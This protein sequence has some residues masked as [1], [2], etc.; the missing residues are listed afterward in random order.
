MTTTI[1]TT[2]EDGESPDISLQLLALSQDAAARPKESDGMLADA[3]MRLTLTETPAF[4]KQSDAT[5]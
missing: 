4:E 1:F 3:L 2:D 5:L